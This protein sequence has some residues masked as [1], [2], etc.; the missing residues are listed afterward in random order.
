M[1]LKTWLLCCAASC[2]LCSRLSNE[3]VGDDE[4]GVE[5]G[6]FVILLYNLRVNVSCAEC[7]AI[8]GNY[9]LYHI[10]CFSPG[11]VRSKAAGKKRTQSSDMAP[12]KEN[13]Q[14]EASHEFNSQKWHGNLMAN[15]A[16]SAALSGKP[17]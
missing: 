3:Q 12:G 4:I 14:P 10:S 5:E 1:I 6:Q 16:S 9:N 7:R 17:I 8:E 2:K 13:V 11:N 15:F